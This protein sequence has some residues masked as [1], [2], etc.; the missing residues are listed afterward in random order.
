MGGLRTRPVP[1]PAHTGFALVEPLVVIAIL[2]VR[3]AIL[4]PAF[5]EDADSDHVLPAATACRDDARRNP[6]TNSSVGDLMP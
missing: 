4:L 2:A 6:G 5:R 1:K 3:M